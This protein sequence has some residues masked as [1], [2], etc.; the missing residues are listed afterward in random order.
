LSKGVQRMLVFLASCDSL[1]RKERAG[2]MAHRQLGLSVC[3]GMR[4]R[5][6]RFS[7]ASRE[8]SRTLLF[9]W[10]FPIGNDSLPRSVGVFLSLF[11]FFSLWI[12]ASLILFFPRMMSF[13]SS[14]CLEYCSILKRRGILP[15]YASM[16]HFAVL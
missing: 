12:P 8:T 6:S 4:A 14:L 3:I 5:P 13:S 1:P 10:S 16:L 2:R 9:G 7:V 11:C 15:C